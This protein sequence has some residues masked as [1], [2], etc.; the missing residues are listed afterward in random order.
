MALFLVAGVV[1]WTL[2]FKEYR[3]KDTVNIHLFPQVIGGWTA[4]ELPITEDEYAILETRNAFARQYTHPDGRTVYLL[5]VYSQNNRKVSHPPE[6]CYTGNGVTIT[7]KKVAGL[8]LP[9][10]YSTLKVNQ[11]VLEQKGLQQVSNY[12]FKVGDVFTPSYWQ[13]QFLIALK[14]LAGQPASSALIRMSANSEGN[15]QESAKQIL[16]DFIRLIVPHLM[17]YLP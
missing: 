5:I 16:E 14:T 13:Q 11:L 4:T 17:E 12:W 2:F 1:S 7:S 3:Q 10:P 15:N 9:A 6:V 8:D